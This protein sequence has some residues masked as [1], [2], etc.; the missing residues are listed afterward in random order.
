MYRS[1]TEWEDDLVEVSKDTILATS[2][3]AQTIALHEAQSAGERVDLLEQ[4]MGEIDFEEK[5]GSRKAM[6]DAKAKYEKLKITFDGAID[7]ALATPDA[8][9]SEYM[10]TELV[11]AFRT[12]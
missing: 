3:G 12:R 11:R 10:R 5:T 7:L 9:M 6:I 1:Y 8:D 2:L 4:M